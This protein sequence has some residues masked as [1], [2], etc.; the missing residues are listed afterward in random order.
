MEIKIE[1]WFI[2]QCLMHVTD[3]L[4]TFDKIRDDFL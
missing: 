4:N 3:K 2:Y 1:V